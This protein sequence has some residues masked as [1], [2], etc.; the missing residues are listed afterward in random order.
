[1]S[2]VAR[3][4]PQQRTCRRALGISALC[5]GRAKTQP[6]IP[7]G[8]AERE[9]SKFSRSARPYASKNENAPD[10]IR[11]FTRVRRETGKE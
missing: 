1:M 6:A 8:R 11:V 3:I 9:I 7:Y 2:V 5:R 10:A 4:S